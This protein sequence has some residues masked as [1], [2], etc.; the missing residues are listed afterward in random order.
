[1]LGEDADSGKSTRLKVFYKGENFHGGQI[2]WVE[3]SPKKLPKKIAK[4]NNRVAIKIFKFKDH[5]Q[6]PSRAI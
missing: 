1:M 5:E 6:P 4:A 3:R 2:G